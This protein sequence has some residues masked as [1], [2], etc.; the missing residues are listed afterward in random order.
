MDCLTW[1]I[2]GFW[3][4]ESVVSARDVPESRDGSLPARTRR[5]ALR[6]SSAGELEL[7]V[8]HD[9]YAWLLTDPET[10]VGSDPVADIPEL[11]DLP[12]LIRLK[13]MT[14]I[15]RWTTCRRAPGDLWRPTVT[16]ER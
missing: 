8:P 11:D 13:Y 5:H 16:I 10:C 4:L 9:F 6:V 14:A 12:V 15:N 3:D 2:P 7:R 1:G